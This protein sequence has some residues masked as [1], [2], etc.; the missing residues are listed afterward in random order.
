VYRAL[1]RKIAAHEESKA[2]SPLGLTE[3]REW[4]SGWADRLLALEQGKVMSQ[5]A[6]I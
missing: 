6:A 1:A 4:A 3:L 5:G 2:P